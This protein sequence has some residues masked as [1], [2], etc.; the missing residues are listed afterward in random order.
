M[1]ALTPRAGDSPAEAV[2]GGVEL[3]LKT[4][5]DNEV[6]SPAARDAT[7]R[8]LHL[9][10]HFAIDPDPDAAAMFAAHLA[11]ALERAAEGV[12]LDPIEV[13]PGDIA[14]LDVG[15]A[16]AD[17]LILECRREGFALPDY[18]RVLIALHVAAMILA[19]QA[20]NE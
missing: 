4:L 19:A 15:F 9:L 13:P 3:R 1:D 8:C 5:L 2:E 10:T 16:A 17:H 6:I 7:M 20:R 14:R 11:M 12:T 18:E